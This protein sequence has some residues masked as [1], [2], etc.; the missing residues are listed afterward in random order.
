MKIVNVQKKEQKSKPLAYILQLGALKNANK[1]NKIVTQLRLSGY[2]VF[3]KP[4][5][6]IQGEITRIYIGPDFSKLKLKSVLTEV[7]H[8]SG[9]IG[10]VKPDR[11]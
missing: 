7:K 4:L 1:V 2:H 9:L 3:T 8:L 5:S 11:T 10:I 6:P